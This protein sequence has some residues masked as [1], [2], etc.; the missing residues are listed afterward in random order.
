MEVLGLQIEREHVR[1]DR[2]HR[3][4]DVSRRRRLEVSRC[5]QRSL[6][7]FIEVLRLRRYALLHDLLL[8]WSM[9]LGGTTSRDRHPDT[10][11]RVRK[12]AALSPDNAICMD[13]NA[14]SGVD[15]DPWRRHS[16]ALA[17]GGGA[18]LPTS[19]LG[20]VC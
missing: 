20:R 8:C 14:G 3:A 4:C 16:P 13:S 6:L 10:P 18:T 7:S 9:N 5:E 1:E 12:P 2:I 11:V 19:M 15:G 17:R